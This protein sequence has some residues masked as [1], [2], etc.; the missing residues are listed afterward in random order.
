M[1]DGPFEGGDEGNWSG[2]ANGGIGGPADADKSSGAGPIGDTEDGGILSDK[3]PPPLSAPPIFDFE[4][5][6]PF[7][8]VD[9]SVRLAPMQTAIVAIFKPRASCII[10]K[11]RT[12]PLL[13]R[14]FIANAGL[15]RLRRAASSSVWG[16]IVA[17]AGIGDI[18]CLYEV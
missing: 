11:L 3:L 17:P 6:K 1:C 10:A 14:L 13:H 18:F 2:D 15:L 16:T 7:A 8:I 9:H 5:G 12:Q 4:N